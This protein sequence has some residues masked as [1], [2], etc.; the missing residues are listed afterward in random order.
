M[1]KQQFDLKLPAKPGVLKSIFS[2]PWKGNFIQDKGFTIESTNAG[3]VSQSSVK[4]NYSGTTQVLLDG[5]PISLSA[6]DKLFLNIPFSLVI[7]HDQPTQAIYYST[8]FDNGETF[9]LKEPFT[10]NLPSGF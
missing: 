3:R 4:F 6:N 1:I 10:K 8:T 5:K 7:K 9:N 2:E